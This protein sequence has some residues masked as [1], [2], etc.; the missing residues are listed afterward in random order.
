MAEP[1]NDFDAFVRRQQE[2][3][4]EAAAEHET[5]FDAKAEVAEWKRRLV[6][7]FSQ[8][9]GFLREYI[10]S[11]S[12]RIESGE[13]EVAEEFSGP[14]VAPTMTIHIGLEEIRLIP[15]G[16]RL[17]GSKGRV[18]VIGRAGSS[19]LVL[20]NRNVDYPSQLFKIEIIDPRKSKLPKKVHR[21]PI[22]W[23]W[24]IASRPPTIT[25]IDLNKDTLFQLLL[26]V[27][28]A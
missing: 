15:I 13:I 22:E 19:R 26:E 7:L 18:D 23:V 2:I 1:R 25:F 14:Y 6:A 17:F 5:P 3:A 9:E 27:S 21:E 4:A 12:I 10:S 11:G 24:K 28:N 8:I 20:L 16:T